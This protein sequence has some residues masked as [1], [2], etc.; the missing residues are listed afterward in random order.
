MSRFQEV[1]FMPQADA[2]KLIPM[3]DTALISITGP[4]GEAQLKYGWT[5]LLRLEFHDADVEEFDGCLLFDSD[6]ARQVIQFVEQLPPDV[7]RFFVHCHAGISRSAGVAK[8]VAEMT[9]TPF[10]KDYASYNRLVYSTLRKT[11][12]GDQYGQGGSAFSDL[13]PVGAEQ[14]FED[15]AVAIAQ[16]P[17][18][19]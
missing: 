7:T 19:R 6:M 1:R 12:F 15:E 14:A 2:V 11:Y 16:R 3:A 9:D 5:H 18:V 17:K 4:A 8:F 10:N 13:P